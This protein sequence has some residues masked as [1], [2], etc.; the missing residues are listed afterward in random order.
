VR[1]IS[2]RKWRRASPGKKPKFSKIPGYLSYL[3][4]GLPLRNWV[5][6]RPE[7]LIMTLSMV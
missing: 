5:T 7:P 6:E 3:I 2:G 1:L 4:A